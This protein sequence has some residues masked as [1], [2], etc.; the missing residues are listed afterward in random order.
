MWE[1][2]PIFDQMPKQFVFSGLI[3]GWFLPEKLARGPSESGTIDC[4]VNAKI[5]GSPSPLAFAPYA[6]PRPAEPPGE[7]LHAGRLTL[8]SEGSVPN[9]IQCRKTVACN[10]K[11][12][13]MSKGAIPTKRKE[14]FAV[15]SVQS[16]VKNSSMELA[17]I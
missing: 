5:L 3:N 15:A 1:P 4:N 2:V 9:K 8:K 14:Q 11:K 7:G 16:L 12:V 6:T 10:W 17:V 13:S